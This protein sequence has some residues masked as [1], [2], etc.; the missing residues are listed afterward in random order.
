MSE[1]SS[2]IKKD[3]VS[4]Q[5]DADVSV[6]HAEEKKD[7]KSVIEHRLYLEKEI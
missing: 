5:S 3:A 7:F 4:S 1:F 2:K 6:E